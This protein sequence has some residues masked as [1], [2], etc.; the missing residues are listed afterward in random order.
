M[1][2]K[3]PLI[4]CVLSSLGTIL[5]SSLVFIPNINKIS[6]KRNIMI[7]SSIVMLLI[8]ILDL[9]PTN[10]INIINTYNI[11]GILIS[12]ILFI[13]GIL[14]VYI[15]NNNINEINIY[16]RAGI[17]NFIGIILHNVPEGIATFISSIINPIIG[18][19][20]SLIIML[21]NIPEGLLIMI[22]HSIN[23]KKRRGL[24]LSL[25]A[26]ISEP[27]GGLIFYL[28]LKNYINEFTINYILIYVSGLMISLAI[29]N[30]SNKNL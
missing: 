3:I 4:I 9:I 12:I 8:A 5:G 25:I 10:L 26:G 15:I 2:I 21:H 24:I 11:K 28:I 29:E 20:L 14:T 1:N 22:P 30:I 27:I 13:L 19:K 18:L 7:I 6:Y 17:L 16:S 23:N